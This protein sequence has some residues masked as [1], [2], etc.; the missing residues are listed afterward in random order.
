MRRPVGD[1]AAV[2]ALEQPLLAERLQVTAYCGLADPELG[3]E[4]GDG[5]RAVARQQL[6]DAAEPLGL[7]HAGTLSRIVDA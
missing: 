6:E 2:G 4:F 5:D 7:A 1:G 3:R